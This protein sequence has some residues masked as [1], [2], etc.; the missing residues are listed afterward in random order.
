M[1]GDE[2]APAIADWLGQAALGPT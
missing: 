1:L 2:D